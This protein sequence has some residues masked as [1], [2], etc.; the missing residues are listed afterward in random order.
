MGGT[1]QSGRRRGAVDSPAPPR[2]EVIP[3]LASCELPFW[4]LASG[5]WA[6][7]PCQ[8]WSNMTG[9]INCHNKCSASYW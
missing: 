4:G 9:N 6:Y 3:G 1:H 5:V 8:G 2:P 7:G